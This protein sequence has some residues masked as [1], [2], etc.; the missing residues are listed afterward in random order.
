MVAQILTELK[1]L[2][3]LWFFEYIPNSW[4]LQSKYSLSAVQLIC[5]LY[6]HR[7]SFICKHPWFDCLLSDHSLKFFATEWSSSGWQNV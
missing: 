3:E 6:T 5:L 2:D 1:L 7:I 4:L